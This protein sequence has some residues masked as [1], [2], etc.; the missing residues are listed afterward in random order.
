[1]QTYMRERQ[2]DLCNF[3]IRLVGKVSDWGGSEGELKKQ[4]TDF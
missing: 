3:D 4:D 1:M 2:V